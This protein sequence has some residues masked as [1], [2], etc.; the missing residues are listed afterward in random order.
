MNK[1]A[2]KHKLLQHA[3]HQEVNPAISALE[4]YSYD[5]SSDILQQNKVRACRAIK[6][7]LARRLHTYMKKW[8]KESGHYKISLKSA[9]AARITRSYYNNLLFAFARWRRQLL[10]RETQIRTGINDALAVTVD[11]ESQTAHKN[12]SYLRLLEDQTRSHKRVL[13]AKTMRKF[14]DRRLAVAIGRWMDI[15][16][17]RT[18]QEDRLASVIKRYRNRQLRCAINSYV[19]FLKWSRQHDKNMNG[20]LYLRHKA[21]MRLMQKVFDAMA[22]YTERNKRAHHYW[23]KILNR[24]DAFMRTRAIHTWRQ[25]AGISYEKELMGIQDQMTDSIYKRNQLLCSMEKHV[26]E[27]DDHLA[28]QKKLRRD[29][30]YRIVGNYFVRTQKDRMVNVF[31]D[32][33]FTVQ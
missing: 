7:Q 12:E 16:N 28:G 19:V 27:Q 26:G 6:D 29:R 17:M 1:E 23:S 30:A 3:V 13:V 15:C 33:R 31:R 22:W 4:S 32:W 24:M 25:N 18:T 11:G 5:K 21:N 10:K 8:M 9:L 20:M 14:Q 2:R